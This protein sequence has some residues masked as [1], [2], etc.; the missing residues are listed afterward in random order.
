M[1]GD[2]VDDLKLVAGEQFDQA[3]QYSKSIRAKLFVQNVGVPLARQLSSIKSLVKQTCHS[4]PLA[5]QISTELNSLAVM[6]AKQIEM[7]LTTFKGVDLGHRPASS[8]PFRENKKSFSARQLC[9]FR[10]LEKRY[11]NVISRVERLPDQKDWHPMD[12]LI[13]EV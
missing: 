10:E 13:I 5:E 4:K 8:L 1:G 7:H 11:V 6:E 12:P 9:D 3:Q 2:F